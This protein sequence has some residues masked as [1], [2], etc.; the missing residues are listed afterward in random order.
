MKGVKVSADDET[1]AS[2]MYFVVADSERKN[3]GYTWRIWWGGT[4][5]YIKGRASSLAAFKISLH[6]PDPAR[7]QLRPGFKIAMDE[8]AIAKATAAGAVHCGSVVIA[9]QWFSGRRIKDGVTH[10]LTFRTTWDLFVKNVPPASNP[11][12]LPSGTVGL[13][14]PAPATFKAADLD[15]YVSDKKPYWPREAKARRDNA[16]IGPIQSRAGQYLTGV[17]FRRSALNGDAP[18]D[19]LAL[20]SRFAKDHIRG[21]GTAVDDRGVLWIIEQWMS[22]SALTAAVEYQTQLTSPDAEGADT[23]AVHR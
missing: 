4:S 14:I 9:P 18:V 16:C 11:G 5:F 15:I 1:L 13:V 8:S 2:A 20:K 23:S 21:I 6:G 7:P 22:P 19:A 17:S 10:A 12:E 3:R